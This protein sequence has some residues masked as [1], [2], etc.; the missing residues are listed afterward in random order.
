M[1]MLQERDNQL[2]ERFPDRLSSHYFN[3]FFVNKLIDAKEKYDYD[4]VKRYDDYK[5]FISN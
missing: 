1:H 2:C 3:S 5:H 4:T